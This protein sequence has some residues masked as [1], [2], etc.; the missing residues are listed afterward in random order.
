MVLPYIMW[1]QSWR[2]KYVEGRCMES[3]II[4][5]FNL[6]LR[7][8]T[9]SIF[10]SQ[11]TNSVLETGSACVFR[12][13]R[14]RGEPTPVFHASSFEWAHQGRFFP[15]CIPHGDENRSNLQSI[16][17]FFLD[18][19]DGQCSK[20]QWWLSSDTIIRILWSC[21]V[22]TFVWISDSPLMELCSRSCYSSNPVIAA[23][24]VQVMTRIVCYW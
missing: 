6:W 19:D 2:V 7:F 13:N 16:D 22:I 20:F 11:T 18:W 17:V 9:L 12:W 3:S 21:V 1:L 8:W 23:K 10:S 5:S 15:F 4:I 24:A 14:K